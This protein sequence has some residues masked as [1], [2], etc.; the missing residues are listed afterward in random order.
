[1]CWLFHEWTKWEVYLH[2]FTATPRWG[3]CAGQMF[4]CVE[5]RQRRRCEKCGKAQDVEIG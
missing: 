5:N 1:M 2:E 3:K 4:N